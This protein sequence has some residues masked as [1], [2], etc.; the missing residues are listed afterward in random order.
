MPRIAISSPFFQLI[1]KESRS[2]GKFLAWAKVMVLTLFKDSGGSGLTTPSS[3]PWSFPYP[4]EDRQ[5]LFLKSSVKEASESVGL[6]PGHLASSC[7]LW[8]LGTDSLG[9]QLWTSSDKL[10]CGWL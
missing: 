7:G 1:M 6:I 9:A 5:H 10:D 3:F 8:T 2:L 4:R